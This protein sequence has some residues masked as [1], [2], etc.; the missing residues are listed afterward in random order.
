MSFMKIQITLTLNAHVSLLNLSDSWGCIIY[1]NKP[2]NILK[3]SG[4][5]TYRQ[6]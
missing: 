2:I 6:V 1:V 3:P 5:F 4:K